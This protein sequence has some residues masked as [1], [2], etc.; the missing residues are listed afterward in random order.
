MQIR[1]HIRRSF[2]LVVLTFACRDIPEVARLVLYTSRTFAIELIH[3][4]GD[5]RT[6]RLECLLIRCIA[7][8]NVH[9]EGHRR[10]FAAPRESGTAAAHHQ[11]GIADADL[12]MNAA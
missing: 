6:A 3:W 2:P 1:L 4:F 7:V 9:V 10:G 12:C 8:S 11:H 5:R